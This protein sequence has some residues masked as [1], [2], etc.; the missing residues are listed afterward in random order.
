MTILSP[1]VQ[2]AQP[3]VIQTVNLGTLRLLRLRQMF[4]S[5]RGLGSVQWVASTLHP[6]PTVAACFRKNTVATEGA[7]T[8]TRNSIDSNRRGK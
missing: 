1:H 5:H 4:P 3:L 8:A 2:P 6:Y 7:V